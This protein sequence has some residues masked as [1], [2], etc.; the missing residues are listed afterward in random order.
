MGF[1]ERVGWFS[2]IAERETKLKNKDEDQTCVTWHAV[3]LKGLSENS[4]C[5]P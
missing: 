5:K 1:E 3:T 4:A 2:R